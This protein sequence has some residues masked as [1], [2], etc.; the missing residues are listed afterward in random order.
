MLQNVAWIHFC[1]QYNVRKPPRK[2]LHLHKTSTV[3]EQELR[4]SCVISRL[5][6]KVVFRQR[7]SSVKGRLSSKVFFGQRSSSIKV[8]LPWKVVFILFNLIWFH[9]LNL[10]QLSLNWCSTKCGTAQVSL[11]FFFLFEL[12]DHNDLHYL[13]LRAGPRQ[14][15]QWR[16]RLMSPA[17]DLGV[18]NALNDDV[19]VEVDVE[20]A[21]K[22]SIFIVQK[23]AAPKSGVEF[24]QDSIGTIRNSLVT[25]CDAL[26]R[27]T[28]STNF[29]QS[30]AEKLSHTHTHTQTD[31]ESTY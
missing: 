19:V 20:E 24:R 1:S 25:S 2:C 31:R 12:V 18:L 23:A 14:W 10:I 30:E 9:F 29:D 15:L 3:P 28:T 26:R 4:S 27:R 22:S 5:P 8:R 7:S 16:H 13:S 11:L 21:L 17:L 6:S